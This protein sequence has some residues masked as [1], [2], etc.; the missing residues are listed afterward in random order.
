MSPASASMAAVDG[1]NGVVSL[2]ESELPSELFSFSYKVR[3]DAMRY[4]RFLASNLDGLS[5]PATS[6]VS[7]SPVDY[8]WE[9]IL[10]ALSTAAAQAPADADEDALAMFESSLEPPPP[11]D[12]DSSSD[13][14]QDAINACVGAPVRPPRP[15]YSPDLPTYHD[16]ITT[17]DEN[18]TFD[19][20]WLL[21]QCTLH[22]VDKPNGAFA[23]PEQLCN[24]VL[25]IL[26]STQSDEQI[27]MTLFELLGTDNFELLT[28]LIKHRHDITRSVPPEYREQTDRSPQKASSTALVKRT[29]PQ[30]GT[31]VT[32][33]TESEKQA[34][35]AQRKSQKAK[36]KQHAD[37]DAVYEEDMRR[38]MDADML[39]RMR[40]LALQQGPAAL[41]PGGV[42]KLSKA[43]EYPHI[44]RSGGSSTVG[45][46]MLSLFGSRYT[47]PAGTE[48]IDEK[49]Y[50]EFVIPVNRPAPPRV[51][52]QQITVDMLDDFA[53][54]AYAGY[55]SLNRMQSIVFPTAYKTNENM[56]VCAPTGAGKTDVAMLT[57]LR[58]LSQY[59][60]PSSPAS[61]RYTFAKSDFKIVY[62]APMKALA[63]EVVAKFS[64]RLA[65]LDI[66]VR[67]LTG[68]MQL[69][70]YEIMH[71]Q[72]IVTTPEKWDVVTRKS[73]GD[74]ELAQKVRLL[75]I[76]EVH[77]LHD[78]RGAVL[79]TIVAR[80]QRQ[81]ETTQSLIRI[82]GLSATLPNFI[83]VAHFLRVNPHQGLFYFD[84]GFRPVPLGQHFIGIKG[85]TNS[86]SQKLAMHRV[87]HD[88]CAEQLRGKHQVMVFVHSR[89]DTVKTCKTLIEIA[90]QEDT[91]SLF[92][93]QYIEGYAKAWAEVSK[94]R[95]RE[96]KDLF[97]KGFGIHHAGM[98]RADRNLVERMF[99][100]GFI[101]VLCCTATLA[102][103]V[104][105]PAH[106]VIIKGTDVYDAQKGSFVDLSILDVLQIFG[107]AGRPQYETHG[108]GFILTPHEK[109]SHYVSAVT[110]QQPIESQFARGLVDNLNAEVSLGTVT[111]VDEAMQWLGYTYLNVRMKKNPMH[112][113]IDYSE[114]TEDPLLAKRRRELIEGAATTLFRNRMI[115][116][117]PTTGLLAPRDLGRIA[118]NYYIKTATVELFN[119]KL[120]QHMS[121]T[122]VLAV[123]SQ[124][125][126]FE[127][128]KLR[129]E[130]AREL[131]NMK[132]MYCSLDVKG[133]TETS[134]GK[135]NILLQ[136]YISHAPID[137]FALVSDTAY[138]AQNAGR[139]LR[140]VFEV[141]LNQ[142]WSVATTSALNLCKAVEK[143]LW[144]Y[145]HPLSQFD[146]PQDVLERLENHENLTVEELRS[147]TASDIGNQIRNYKY[148]PLI[149]RCAQ[150]FPIIEATAKVA[151]ITNTVL[152]V[153]LEL[154]PTF[155]WNDK[156]HGTVEPWWV[157]AQDYDQ[158]EIYHSEYL[159]ITR[160]QCYEPIKLSFTI[161]ISNPPPAQ[162]HIH[163][164]SD[165][166]LDAEVSVPLSFKHLILPQM[167]QP[168]TNLLDLEPLPVTA[169]QDPVL[170][171]LCAKRFSFFNAIQT[172]T[173]YTLY[174]TQSN[175]LLGAPTGSG[176]TMAAELALWQVPM[177]TLEHL[178]TIFDSRNRKAFQDAPKSKVVYIAPLKALV[179][180]R[181]D[182]WR[183]RLEGPMQRRLVELTGD[184]TPDLKTIEAA[185]IIIT[186]PEKWD[187]VSRNWQTRTYV[188]AVSCVIIDEIH[189]LGGDR[190]PILEVI[191][192]R[193][194]YM[195]EKTGRKVRI[196]GLSTALANAHDLA[197]WLGIRDVG[198]FN[199]R[200]SVRPVQLEVYIDGFPGKHYCVRLL[201]H[202]L[203]FLCQRCRMAT[204][205][206]P[207]YAAIMQHSPDKP[208]IVFVSSRRQTRLT[209]QDLISY[210]AMG[211]NPR[212]F[213]KLAEDELEGVLAQVKDANLRHALTFGIGLHHA[214]LTES[215]R[216]VVEALFVNL[217]IQVLVATST[218]AWGVNT[219]AHLVIVK[220]TEFF[221]AKTKK[222]I[223]F[224]ITDVLQMMG[225]AGRPQYDDK[226]VA[227]IF[228]QD[229]KKNFYKK[230]L[231]EPFPVESSLHNH[232]HDHINA[233]IV[234]G[235]IK[236]KQDA[237]DYLTWTYFFRRLRMNPTYYGAVDD[238]AESINTF[239]SMSIERT[240]GA[241]SL[242]G[243]VEVYEEFG[244][245]ATALGK[246]ASYYYLSYKTMQL[247][248]Q[249]VKTN[250]TFDDVLTVLCN[251][252]EYEELPVRH[253]EDIHNKEL[254]E[255]VPLPVN[256]TQLDSPHVKA[257]LLLQAHMSRVALPITDYHTDTLSVLD[258]AIRILQAMIDF[259]VSKGWLSVALHAI[260]VMQGLKQG[261]WLYDESLL[262]L[263]GLT[264]A[265]C[266]Q[267]VW[268][269]KRVGCLAEL[270][271]VQRFDDAGKMLARVKDLSPDDAKSMLDMW[272]NLPLLD[273][274]AEFAA[275]PPSSGA[276]DA[277]EAGNKSTLRVHLTRQAPLGH[278]HRTNRDL[279][280]H[281]PRFPKAQ[282]EGWFVVVGDPRTKTVCG[283]KRVSMRTEDKS[284]RH[285]VARVRDSIT[286]DVSIR[287]DGLRAAAAA[288][289]TGKY[290]VSVF[291]M[292]DAYIG[293]DQVLEVDLQ[294]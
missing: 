240:L 19:R 162:V 211:D 219:P 177:G 198:L 68:D 71:T 59:L 75:I 142:S 193:M 279:R 42:S 245:E 115:I 57:V 183:A 217:K 100:S 133:G 104:N 37:F 255:Y 129:E 242:A 36:H 140:A 181:V 259:A 77:L 289:A 88:R 14:L 288:T 234:A 28:A 79:E 102:W 159:L 161:P 52:E 54:P 197:D 273:V 94:S 215:D 247:F 164:V 154:V 39:R 41:Q 212:R 87:C 24:A 101:K 3:R 227:C 80:T 7:D 246:L 23:H 176:K 31:T 70:K 114:I 130:E 268:K 124:S 194:N 55:K 266:D 165:R 267:L 119:S 107:R 118:S 144:S 44:Y 258:Q 30:Y 231:H 99:E 232:L 182:D 49:D 180:E 153:D 166:W 209:A 208:V 122:D 146:L 264:P 160:K 96:L 65:P 218:L 250:S 83:D 293:L 294:V 93:P 84:N 237:V 152:R 158:L 170:V 112:Y 64:K 17:Y 206:K 239:L 269:G 73:T 150:Q 110:Q 157:W 25:D 60:H 213:L 163:V 116:F 6:G 21:E 66:Q 244:L 287:T 292:S 10:H 202:F 128:V 277:A 241:L 192:S 35:K 135:I 262:Q 105:L 214:G 48:R 90:V 16:A 281:A 283:M 139:L 284:S 230:F 238:S 187:G 174:Q 276:E 275:P 62:V 127:N 131:K 228:V 109:L 33:V 8:E 286:T 143:R 216:K 175:V 113:G 15:S 56:L 236:T 252:T 69:T 256:Q 207:T 254:S 179:R 263:P 222:Y 40:E 221:D 223:D 285:G 224:P 34:A 29:M 74:N 171:E 291:V 188:R 178:G 185:D 20:P 147:M 123:I 117:E 278:G 81:V 1:D 89:K 111:T 265:M 51:G 204:M 22:L 199:F 168:H 76:D 47:M 120:N 184:V 50:E 18:Q 151:P 11:F 172:Q 121:E 91:T 271:A 5:A 58:T 136:S 149:H 189:L 260:T 138:V 272:A 186:T 132:E 155:S 4:G 167:Y 251:A 169:L 195:S 200:H 225:R 205:N 72:M 274:K 108:V 2:Y 253:N 27:Q 26:R 61:R 196:V 280:V 67:E 282:Y 134:Y 290:P 86:P 137:D 173:F 249:Q 220:G 233:E 203:L 103:G 13:P 32:V 201:S 85:K 78:E 126:E 261:R 257:L 43:E 248:Q 97:Q 243:C 226:G 125:S 145:F 92:D 210:C 106:A 148:G 63:A 95:N 9:A 141:C 45:G 270:M 12:F 82:V 46:S 235:T 156:V 38:E 191:V 53:Q 98:L 190:G 229:V